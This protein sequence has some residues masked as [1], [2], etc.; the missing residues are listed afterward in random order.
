MLR[1]STAVR[2]AE[3]LTPVQNLEFLTAL[4]EFQVKVRIVACG[5]LL[6]R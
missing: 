3:I 4:T 1:T 5:V 6:S 2:V